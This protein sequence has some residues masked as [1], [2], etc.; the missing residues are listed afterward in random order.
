MNAK[1]KSK[2]RTKL[3]RKKLGFQEFSYISYKQEIRKLYAKE[4]YT[5]PL[6]LQ[7]EHSNKSF[8]ND[9]INTDESVNDIF[10]KNVDNKYSMNLITDHMLDFGNVTDIKEEEM[11]EHDKSDGALSTREDDD[12]LDESNI[13]SFLNKSHDHNSIVSNS[14]NKKEYSINR[15]VL[16]NNGLISN[17]GKNKSGTHKKLEIVYENETIV[18][19]KEYENQKKKMINELLHIIIT[20]KKITKVLRDQLEE[21]NKN[22]N[23]YASSSMI[24][25]IVRKVERGVYFSELEALTIHNV[26]FNNLEI[27]IVNSKRIER[28]KQ[29]IFS[30]D[31][32]ATIERAIIKIYK[33]NTIR[34]KYAR[35]YNGLKITEKEFLVCLLI[36]CN[37]IL[38]KEQN[39]TTRKYKKIK[40]IYGFVKKKLYKPENEGELEDSKDKKEHKYDKKGKKQD[41]DVKK[42]KKQE[43]KDKD[44]KKIKKQEDKDKDKDDKKIKAK[45]EQRGY[46]SSSSSIRSSSVDKSYITNSK[47]IKNVDVLGILEK[48]DRSKKKEKDTTKCVEKNRKDTKTHIGKNK[49]GTTTHTEKNKQSTTTHTEKSKQ[50]TATNIEKNRKSTTT[51]VEKNIPLKTSIYTEN[52]GDNNLYENKNDKKNI[53]YM[54]YDL[55]NKRDTEI[56]ELKCSIQSIGENMKMLIQKNN[57]LEKDVKFIQLG[58]YNFMRSSMKHVNN[59]YNHPTNTL[60]KMCPNECQLNKQSTS[61]GIYNDNNTDSSL[62]PLPLINSKKQESSISIKDAEK[63]STIYNYHS[64]LNDLEEEE[65]GKKKKKKNQNTI[66][67]LFCPSTNKY[68]NNFSE[69]IK[70]KNKLKHIDTVN[71]KVYSNIIRDKYIQKFIYKTS[72]LIISLHSSCSNTQEAMKND[73][74]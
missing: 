34:L 28:L 25:Y 35:M 14:N 49:Q 40:G 52:I 63:D 68:N 41:K 66:Q 9:D 50:G 2:F 16:S 32:L 29:Y 67:S 30:S 43:D 46:S 12:N 56:K 73:P 3:K 65:E 74:S 62:T 20:K 4:K 22:I 10:P 69:T 71:C 53:G 36:V 54:I 44:D 51:N 45:N 58:M 72:E 55:L 13:F 15:Y 47:S 31:R 24:K 64:Y 17:S 27:T 26:D 23:Y 21:T 48:I 59:E 7:N 70:R 39:I 19:D 38:L 6:P 61:S 5:T 37:Y 60:L 8:K 18:L 1:K 33:D 11:E 57:S 42:I